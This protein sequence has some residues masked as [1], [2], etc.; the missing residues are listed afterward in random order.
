M[1]PITP[2]VAMT[3]AGSDNS[4]GAGLQADLKTFH[5]LDVYGL[6]AVTCVV[7]E[8]PGLVSMIEALPS[9]LVAEQITLG[10]K[11]FPVQAIKTGMLFSAE[12][13]HVV[14][15]EISAARE[16]GLAF[17]L[18]VDPVMVASSGDP[19]LQP[20]AVEAYK[21]NLF[22]LA[23]LVTPNLDEA[24]VLLGRKISSLVE[25]EIAGIELACRFGVPFLLKGGHLGGEIATDLLVHPD[26]TVERFEAPFVQGLSPH[27][28]GCTFSSAI[29]AMLARQLPLSQAV[30]SGKNFITA[31]I[32]RHLLWDIDGTRTICLNHWSGPKR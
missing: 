4:A 28:T 27:G 1:H 21:S 10:F 20:D 22:P 17:S 14:A 3:I 31:A 26:E 32:Q 2:Y 29:T 24:S 30:A 18:V 12:L 19:L 16:R 11:A 9:R 7:A 25:L 13:I 6:T 15:S 23:N 8:V 5:E